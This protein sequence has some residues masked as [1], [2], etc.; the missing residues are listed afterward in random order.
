MLSSVA[1]KN[2]VCPHS[3]CYSALALKLR[4]VEAKVLLSQFPFHYHKSLP[5]ITPNLNRFPVLNC[6]CHSIYSCCTIFV[7]YVCASTILTTFPLKIIPQLILKISKS[8]V[9]IIPMAH[10][11]EF[12]VKFCQIWCKINE[13]GSTIFN[14]LF[15][16]KILR[17]MDWMDQSWGHCI[18][19]STCRI[20]FS[21]YATIRCRPL[22]LHPEVIPTTAAVQ[23]CK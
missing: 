1:I 20:H 17:A 18:L 22:K 15:N 6:H 4:L 7:K 14:N 23:Q 2:G 9:S 19:I 21:K 13:N 10:L 3:C 11:W 16:F 12:W 5:S 8:Y